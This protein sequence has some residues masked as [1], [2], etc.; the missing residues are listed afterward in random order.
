MKSPTA[1]A[2]PL[3]EPPAPVAAAAP[4]ELPKATLVEP[5]P[6][7]PP[8]PEEIHVTWEDLKRDAPAPLADQGPLHCP[9]CWLR[10]DAAMIPI[11]ALSRKDYAKTPRTG[12][13]RS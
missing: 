5:P 6:I 9:A 4:A 8:E 13:S 10:F 1:A 3:E 2:D 12:L 11:L 7:P